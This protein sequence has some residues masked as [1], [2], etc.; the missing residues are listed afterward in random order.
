MTNLNSE[1]IRRF[2]LSDTHTLIAVLSYMSF[3]ITVAFLACFILRLV[4]ECH[5]EL[6]HIQFH[7]VNM[8]DARLK[9]CYEYSQLA[10]AD[11]HDVR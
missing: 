8:A 11:G 4:P 5:A 10:H 3:P 2:W 6:F 9:R 1:T 7:I